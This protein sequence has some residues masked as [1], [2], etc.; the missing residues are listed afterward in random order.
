MILVM[1]MKKILLTLVSILL[2]TPVVLAAT[3]VDTN[4]SGSGSFATDWIAD[5][6]QTNHFETGGNF[7]AGEYHAKNNQ[8]NPYGYGVNTVYNW[9]NA[10]VDGGGY[11][12]DWTT[13]DDSKSSY[14]SAGQMTETQMSTSD[15]TLEYAWYSWTNYAEMGNCQYGK[16]TTSNGK[17]FEAS[18]SD[19]YMYHTVTDADGE[20]ASFSAYGSGS[21]MVRLQGEKSSG[22]SFNMGSLPICGD[23]CAWKNNYATFSGSGSGAFEVHGWSDNSLTIGCPSCGSGFTIP[24]S[25]SGAVYDLFIGY[26][27]SWSMPDFGVGGN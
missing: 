12:W 15:G 23:G 17:N 1:N 8:D 7:I 10:V 27:G 13:R 14:G 20:G 6:D 26:T 19:Y 25:G 3:T 9:K 4:W 21:S 5:N 16:S 2:I 18:G 11:I 24:G 22:S